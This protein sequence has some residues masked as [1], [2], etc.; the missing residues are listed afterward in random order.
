VTAEQSKRRSILRDAVEA[1]LVVAIFEA[2]LVGVLYAAGGLTTLTTFLAWPN[3]S[4]WS[5]EIATATLLAG[6][7]FA[8]FRK[9]EQHHA[10]RLAQAKKHHDENMISQAIDAKQSHQHRDR[11]HAEMLEQVEKVAGK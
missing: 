3:G 11:L 1:V 7:L 2:V 10:E 5:N 8:L 4:L 9:L 6:T